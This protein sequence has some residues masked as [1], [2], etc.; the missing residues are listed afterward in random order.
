[1]DGRGE[2]TAADAVAGVRAGAK[3]GVGATRAR[4]PC[5]YARVRRLAQAAHTARVHVG[6]VR[7]WSRAQVVA[8][9]RGRV[10]MEGSCARTECAAEH[11]EPKASVLVV[12]HVGPSDERQQD[13]D[14]G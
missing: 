7:T 6:R 1:M 11:E 2:G 14:A 3:R 13:E 12:Q 8:C 4:A 9:A 10:R 5:D